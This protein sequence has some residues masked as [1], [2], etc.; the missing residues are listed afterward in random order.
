MDFSS[1]QPLLCGGGYL[2][3]EPHSTTAH[4]KREKQ[5]EQRTVSE[6]ASSEPASSHGKVLR[7]EARGGTHRSG[8]DSSAGASRPLHEHTAEVTLNPQ[9][10]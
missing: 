2:G 5:L 9:F 6:P 10:F 7:K 4:S 1:Q 3:R 8:W